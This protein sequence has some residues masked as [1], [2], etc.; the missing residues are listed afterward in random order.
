MPILRKNKIRQYTTIDNYLLMDKKLSLKAKGLLV[1]MLSKP[2]DW[3]F[4]YKN[5]E[6]ELLEGR[7]C[8]QST[9]KELRS[10]KYLKL[11]RV[12]N[13]NNR[14]EWIY[15]ISEIP[16]DLGLKND[17][18]QQVG[19][20]PIGIQSIENQSILLNTNNNKDKIDK[21]IEELNPLTKNIIDKKYIDEDDSSIFCYDNLFNEKLND[22]NSYRELLTISNY[23]ISRAVKNNCKD[24]NGTKI[25]NKFG[26][27]KE[28]LIS[29]I[30]K[31]NNQPKELWSEDEEY[32][33]LNDNSK[34]DDMEL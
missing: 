4:N 6:H 18:L 1:Y 8:I 16:F 15:T 30:N 17:N 19:F 9:I 34:D 22:G 11:E 20:Q 26:Y 32:D 14:Y 21:E 7:A 24:E 23:I 5:F 2:D 12:Y 25:Q 27:F 10:L 29:N 28:S 13:P 33:W 31:L 3:H